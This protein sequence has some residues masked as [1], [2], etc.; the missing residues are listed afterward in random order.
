MRLNARF[1]VRA[2]A[3]GVV[4]ALIALAAANEAAYAASPACPSASSSTAISCTYSATG[5]EQT[6]TVP[7]GVDAVTVTAVG[8][9]GGPGGGAILAHGA[10]GHGAAV[11]ATVPLSPGTTTLY[12]E[13]GGAGGAGTLYPQRGGTAPGGFNSG[14]SSLVG[15]GGGG[16]SDVRTCSIGVCD[17]ASTDSR[18]LAAGGGGGGGGGS[19]GPGCG[20]NGGQAGDAL[21]IGAGAGGPG[22]D[23][24]G[25]V[26][27]G[28]GGLGGSAGGASGSGTAEFPQNG[29]PGSLGQGG[30]GAPGVYVSGYGLFSAGAGGGGGYYGGGGG[31]NG[32]ESGGAGGAG[33]SFWIPAATDTSLAIDPTG[34]PMIMITEHDATT[35]T[36]L[37]SS[38]NPSAAGNSVT[39]TAT[40]RPAPDGGTVG[41]VDGD[42]AIEGCQA[43]PVNPTT[44]TATCTPTYTSPGSH[45]IQASYQGDSAFS[46]SISNVLTQQVVPDPKAQITDPPND[47]TYSVGQHVTTSFG[48]T[49]G[50][51]GP[52]LVSCTDSGGG[53]PPT[54][55]LD[56]S[57]V[58]TSTYTVTA[59][60]SDGGSGTARITYTVAA[61]PS[62]SITAPAG[63]QTFAVGQSVP[64][65]FSCREGS[66]GPGISSCT[67]TNGATQPGGTLDTSKPG[68]FTY[69]VT[70]NS[71]DGQTASASITY[72]IAAPPPTSTTAPASG[73]PVAVAPMAPT[74]ASES[75]ATYVVV[76]P[77]NHFTITHLTTR[78]NGTVRFTLILPGPGIADVLETAWLDNFA[79]AASVLQP[80]PGR[81]VFARK[82]LSVSRARRIV[83]TVH[84]N[85]RGKLLVTRHR[86]AVVIRLWV[87]YTPTNGTQRNRGHYGLHI[88]RRARLSR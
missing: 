57:T 34:T 11:T 80:A 7:S 85:R 58:G 68:T 17:P 88:P 64:T 62:A 78:P 40:V 83:V 3:W 18:L 8:A 24:C 4:V 31:G 67:D 70:A 72:T 77:D 16:A 81:F 76:P 15:G 20:G 71:K 1:R 43:Q 12:V 84:P 74:S 42:G 2:L 75:G 35:S 63:R 50:S 45:G 65:T 49:D 32:N 82:R 38:Q 79:V 6:Y 36:T 29:L 19:G 55:V 44:G 87:S 26:P 46:G 22:N 13:V 53:N 86:Y 27:G 69:T 56:T 10:G 14:G 52:G 39:Y 66:S 9:P 48:C 33:S 37:A 30:A 47:Q 54:G 21:V 25:T 60:S 73:N 51:G 59:V 23:H 5:G 41:F 28:D 61:A